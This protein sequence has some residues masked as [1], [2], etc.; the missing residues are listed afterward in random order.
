MNTG[1]KVRAGMQ[2]HHKTP[3]LYTAED[4]RAGGVCPLSAEQAHY[5]KNV[6]RMAE[7]ENIRLFNGREGE[8]LATLSQLGKKGGTADITEKLRD[9]PK[10]GRPVHLL[11]AP[12]KKQRMDFLIEKAVELGAT[13]LHPVITARTE[14]RALKEDRLR[15]QIIEAAE[16]CERMDVP[17]LHPVQALA[18]KIGNWPQG[19]VKLYWCSER[20][21]APHIREFRL[22]SCGFLIGPVGGFDDSEARFLTECGKVQPLSLGERILRAETACLLCLAHVES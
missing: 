3:R 8:F 7:G 15:A 16:Q 17:A 10:P 11:F 2:D 12:I 22:E 18:V 20:G 6:M 14:N 21:N 1:R 19:G 5:L 9:Q 13:D 4:L